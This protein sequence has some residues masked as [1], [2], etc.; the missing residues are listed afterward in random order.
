MEALFNAPAQRLRRQRRLQE[1]ALLRAQAL[2]QQVGR[3]SS[4]LPMLLQMDLSLDLPACCYAW[5]PIRVH[6][7]F[8]RQLPALQA[9]RCWAWQSPDLA[10]FRLDAFP[11]NIP[12]AVVPDF[13]SFQAGF[14]CMHLV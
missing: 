11:K 6:L 5:P 2:L 8:A 1:E 7:T 12:F 13:H 9:A 14:L 3:K 10:G 4:C